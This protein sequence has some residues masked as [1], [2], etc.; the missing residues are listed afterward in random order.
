MLFGDASPPPVHPTGGDLSP[1]PIETVD[2]GDLSVIVLARK[3]DTGIVKGIATKAALDKAV[4]PLTRHLNEALEGKAFVSVIPE[5]TKPEQYTAVA[6]AANVEINKA[7]V[8]VLVQSRSLGLKSL[9]AK[10]VERIIEGKIP[11]TVPV[12]IIFERLHGEDYAA[13]MSAASNPEK[14]TRASPSPTVDIKS[15]AAAEARS[16]ISSKL[17]DSENAIAKMVGEKLDSQ[18]PAEPPEEGPVSNGILAGLMSLLGMGYA[19][20]QGT[21][22]YLARKV[23]KI[24][25]GAVKSKVS[26]KE[27]AA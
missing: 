3:Q 14:Y 11:D 9:I 21:K 12:E 7:V 25:I 1:T 5:R 17:K 18:K 22:A 13:I 2:P 8:L 16:I 23:G 4:G 6:T 27:T 24:A 20:H 26:S 19:G 10:K 15:V